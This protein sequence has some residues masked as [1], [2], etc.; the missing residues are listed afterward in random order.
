MDG[1]AARLS[2]LLTSLESLIVDDAKAAERAALI[3]ESQAI[4]GRQQRADRL[5]RLNVPL[6]TEMYK[7]IVASPELHPHPHSKGTSLVAVQRWM[8]RN[9]LPPCL[10]LVGRHGAGKSVA[11]A[12]AA[13]NYEG[14]STWT[15]GPELVRVFA[16]N[17][18]GDDRKT[19]KRIAKARLSVIDDVGTE[20]DAVR[21]CATLVEVLEQR[22]R[23]KTIITTNLSDVAWRERYADQRLHSRLREAV[24]VADN[25]P[26]LRGMK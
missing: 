3:R 9:D 22:K 12:W 21:M 10:I 14:P 20:I 11:A 23:R 2:E 13:A 15:S 4:E 16:A 5:D 8:C 17:F 7:A 19:Q 18:D 25:G 26:D 24:F 1:S 6:T